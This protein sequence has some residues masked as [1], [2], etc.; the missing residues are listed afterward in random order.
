MDIAVGKVLGALTMITAIVVSGATHG[1]GVVRSL[2]R[3]GVSVTDNRAYARGGAR[4]EH[5]QHSVVARHPMKAERPRDEP[6]PT[7]RDPAPPQVADDDVPT[8]H[9]IQLA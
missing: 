5:G 6:E 3:Q 4:A 2:G 8:C 7:R 1:L 9:A